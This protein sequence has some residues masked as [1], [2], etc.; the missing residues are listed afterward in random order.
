[1]PPFSREGDPRNTAGV[2]GFKTPTPRLPD[3]QASEPLPLKKGT[4]NIF[5]K[6]ALKQKNHIKILNPPLNPLL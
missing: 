1:V 4:T 5:K 3:R 6:L 2:V